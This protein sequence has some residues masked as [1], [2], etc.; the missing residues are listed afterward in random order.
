[1]Q[2]GTSAS[3]FQ[4]L[5]AQTAAGLFENRALRSGQLLSSPAPVSRRWERAPP[6]AP[7]STLGLQPCSTRAWVYSEPCLNRPSTVASQTPR[8]LTIMANDGPDM[9]PRPG[10]REDIDMHKQGCG[11]SCTQVM[12]TRCVR[13]P[14]RLPASSRALAAI[15][16]CA[17]AHHR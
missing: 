4:M 5:H 12:R 14:P 9:T 8:Q 10:E 1:M 2:S 3:M 15:G 16:R 13:S 6:F 11:T 7:I 17:H